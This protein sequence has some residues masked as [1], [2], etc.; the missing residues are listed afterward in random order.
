MFNSWSI[1]YNVAITIKLFDYYL[2][3]VLPVNQFGVHTCLVYTLTHVMV[4]EII[5]HQL[6]QLVVPT[7]KILLSRVVSCYIV[8]LNQVNGIMC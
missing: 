7:M 2:D 4:L 5:V 8:I 3:L 6:Q 1:I